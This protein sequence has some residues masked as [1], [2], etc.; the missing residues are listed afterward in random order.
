[1]LRVFLVL[2]SFLFLI[3]PLHAETQAEI[4]E[5]IKAFLGDPLGPTEPARKIMKFAKESPDHEVSIDLK[6]LPWLEEKTPPPGYPLLLA[7]Y[8]AG[9]LQG[10][11]AN[12]TTKSDSYAGALAVISVYQKIQADDP[13]IQIPS[14]DH[15]RALEKEGKLKAYLDTK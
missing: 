14:I 3:I 2:T 10:Q 11:F 7:A 15:L 9:N 6:V 8:M 1:M 13:S 4:S 12:G 5:A